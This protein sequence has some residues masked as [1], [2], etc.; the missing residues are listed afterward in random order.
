LINASDAGC[1]S[2]SNCSWSSDKTK[3]STNPAL[4]YF[5]KSY[6]YTWGITFYTELTKGLT[7]LFPHSGIGAN[8]SPN[9]DCEYDTSG[10]FAFD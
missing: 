8:Y 4:Y 5:S 2:W 3:N 10:C 1:D 9:P 6:G 7:G